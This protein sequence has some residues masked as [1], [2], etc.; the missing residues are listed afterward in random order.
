LEIN[1]KLEKI[2]EQILSPIALKVSEK[3]KAVAKQTAIGIAVGYLYFGMVAINPLSMLTGVSSLTSFANLR[4]ANI[5]RALVLTGPGAIIGIASG[6]MAWNVYSG[7]TV[8]SLAYHTMPFL[9][10]AVGLIAYNAYKKWGEGFW[11]EITIVGLYGLVMG[12]FV[13]MNLTALSMIF[14]A[15][16]WGKLLAWGA[17]WKVLNH[18]WIPMVGYILLRPI[19]KGIGKFNENRSTK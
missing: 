14:H 1:L 16:P 17:V 5:L 8:L 6:A 11:K 7:R 13:T 4:W 10:I 12:I 18:A 2:M 15:E 9:N 19:I 3:A